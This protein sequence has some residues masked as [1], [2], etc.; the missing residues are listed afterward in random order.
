MRPSTLLIDLDGVLRLWP[1]EYSA[2]E[3]AHDLPLESIG[4]TAFEP[5]LLEQVTT[6]RITDQEWRHEVKRRLAASY[7][8][9]QA[10]AG[11]EAW[12][13]PVGSVHQEV[14][15]LV[16]GARVHCRIGLVTNA[17]DRLSQDLN[18]LELAQHL[19]FVVNSS[20]VGFSKPNPEI[21][22][23]ALTLAGA[24]PHEALFIDDTLSNVLAATELGIQAHHFTSLASLKTFMQSFGLVTNAA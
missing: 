18:A 2:L 12:S 4:R 22:L 1:K 21:F 3:K 9:S 13:S 11:V 7:P 8:S 24:K 23:R 5:L 17:T 20:E 6:G 10:E 14:L 15:C 16:I 19:D